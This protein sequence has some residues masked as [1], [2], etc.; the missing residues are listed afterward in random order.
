MGNSKANNVNSL[1]TYYA[2]QRASATI[3]HY[4][5]NKDIIRH[6]EIG[7][8]FAEYK[9]KL[10][11]IDGENKKDHE[12]LIPKTKVDRYGNKQ[13][14]FNISEDSLKEFEI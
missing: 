8:V 12:Y 11:I 5:N 2:S 4:D 6:R 3:N 9:D 7:K 10:V 1:G 13:V 14:Y